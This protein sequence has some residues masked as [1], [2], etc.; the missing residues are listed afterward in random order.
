MVD[1]VNKL[2]ESDECQS[3]PTYD[4]EGGKG[5][6][7]KIH[8]SSDMVDVCNKRCNIDGCSSRPNFD[9]RGGRG[10]FCGT[11]KEEGMIDVR[12]KKCEA[13]GCEI[14][15]AYDVKGGKGRFCIDHKS[16]DM[17]DVK[18]KRC[19]AIGCQSAP[20]FGIKGGR[21]QFCLSH[22][23]TGMVN[24]VSKHC[25]AEGCELQPAFD[26][27]GGKGRFCKTHKSDSMTDVKSKR[28]EADNCD[29]IPI[30]GIKGDIGRFC[31]THK[32]PEMVDVKNKMCEIEKCNIHA[33]YGTPGYP[34]S[35]CLSHREPGM[36]SHSNARCSDCKELAIWGINWTPRHCEAHKTSDDLNLVER[37]CTSCGLAFVLD[38]KNKC[39]YCS[40]ESFKRAIHAKQN[41]VMDYLDLRDLKGNSTDKVI[42]GGACGMERPDRIYDLKDKIIIFECDEDQHR[43][44]ACECEQTRMV[45]IG[46]SFGGMPVYFIRW[47]PDNYKPLGHKKMEDI[48]KRYKLVADLITDIT[49]NRIV[50][51]NAF[52]SAIYLYYDD[53]SSLA[54]EKW[55]II[56][57]YAKNEIINLSE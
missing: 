24:V 25:E 10:Q 43:T 14:Q 9:I 13:E 23:S 20:S 1:V 31:G 54:E 7:C 33:S 39:E 32:S 38:K 44:R 35:R 46:Q 26:I 53:W 8:K 42:D 5:R 27:K 4:V 28:C 41:A 22:K 45:N 34:I 47:N 40:P 30:F 36:I 18:S 37:P 17:V 57:P 48:K 12:H 15:P 3:R 19:E 29:S 11:H 56:T 21:A 55:Q 50:L 6:Y 49:A 52:V 2:C 51:P 16:V